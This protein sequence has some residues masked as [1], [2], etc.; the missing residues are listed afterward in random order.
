MSESLYDYLEKHL[1][2]FFAQLGVAGANTGIISAH[3]D[4]FYSH[5]EEFEAAGIPF[6]KAVAIGLLTYVQP[7]ARECRETPQG[8]IAPTRWIIENKDRFLP[9]LPDGATA[10]VPDSE[11]TGTPAQAGTF[12]IR[13]AIDRAALRDEHA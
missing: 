3:G 10:V 2:R 4:K 9:L 13:D 5:R 1:M 12:P 11:I 8:W 6:P 7:F